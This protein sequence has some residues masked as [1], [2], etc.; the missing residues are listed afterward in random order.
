M[1]E[2]V[3]FGDDEQTTVHEL[4]EALDPKGQII[5]GRLGHEST[6]LKDGHYIKDLSY[7]GRDIR[8]MVVIDFAAEKVG[9]HPNNVIVL[10][11]WEGDR[12]DRELISL[13]PFLEHLAQQE[14]D[15]R[16]ELELYS[17]APSEK[18]N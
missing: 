3:I 1:Y 6:L 2:V 14:Y 10:P 8:D 16:D 18:F 12:E 17:N 9:N 11:R 13:T 15:V 4:C 7:M 5:S